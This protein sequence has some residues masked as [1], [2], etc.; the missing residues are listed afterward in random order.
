MA[1]NDR[2]QEVLEGRE[3]N[4]I[5]PFLWLHGKGEEVIREYIQK[6]MDTGIR[7]VC[8]ESRPH[9]EFAREG[10]WKDVTVALNEARERGMK[11]WILDDSHFPTGFAN[12]RVREAEDKLKR[13]FLV[14]REFDVEGPLND[15]HIRI[16]LENG[17]GEKGKPLT[18]HPSRLVACLMAERNTGKIWTGTAAD[19][20]ESYSDG[21]LTFHVPEGK[22][23]ISVILEQ[24][25][26]AV[27]SQEDY[28]N[29]LD[30]NS[31]QLLIDEVYESHYI[32]FKEFFGNTLAG[33]FSDEPGF[34][35]LTAQTGF[36]MDMKIGTEM[37]LPW[38]EKVEQLLKERLGEQMKSDLPLLWFE[39]GEEAQKIR[40]H[41]MDIVTDL[42]RENFSDYIGKWCEEHDVQYIGHIIEDNNTHTRLGPSCGHY[43]K[44]L[45]GQHMSGVDVIQ[46]QIMP[47]MNDAYYSF[48]LN[49][50]A[51]GAFYYYGLAKLGTSM[52][53]LETK[54][55][56]RAMCELYGAYGW[57]EGLKLMKWLTDHLLVRGINTYVPHAFSDKEFPDP[58]CPPHF[59]ANGK[60][61]QYPY[62]KYLFQYLNR[63]CHLLNG[64]KAS[65]HA[66]VLYHAEMEWMGDCL[67]FHQV[68][69]ELMENQTDYDVIPIEKLLS[70]KIKDR[71][72][73]GDGIS[74][75]CL[76]VPAAQAYPETLKEWLKEAEQYGFPVYQVTT[77]EFEKEDIATVTIPLDKVAETADYHGCNEIEVSEKIPYLRYYHYTHEKET[78][79]IHMFF[80]ESTLHE[81]DTKIQLHHNENTHIYIYDPY[82]N[83]L[84]IR[85]DWQDGNISLQL[86]PAETLYLIESN[87]S[88]GA[89]VTENIVLK[90][91]RTGFEF[92][93][94]A[95]FYQTPDKIEYV[96]TTTKLKDFF[97]WRPEFA[98]YIYYKTWIEKQER[99]SVLN[100]GNAYEAAE[101]FV[102]GKSAG[103]RINTPYR[104][105]L[106]GML[107]QE[108]NEIVVKIATN[109]VYA[110]CDRFSRNAVISPMGLMGPVTLE[111][112]GIRQAFNPYLPSYEYIPDGEPHVFCDRVYIYG[113]HDSFDGDLYC[114]NDYVCYSA[115][116]TDLS[117]WRYEC[118]IYRKNQDPRNADGSHCLWA[119][120]VT[121]GLDGKYYL[122]YCLDVLPEIGVAVC[123]T[124][125]GKYEFLG[126]VRYP[127]GS[128]LGRR[129]G[130]YIQ[131]DPGIF[132]DSDK[133]IYLYSGNAP[134]RMEDVKSTEKKS[135]QVMKLRS[136]MLTIEEGPVPVIP[137]ILNSRGTGYEGH[138]FFEASSVRKIGER[139]YFVY[140]DVNSSSLCYAVSEY[141]DSGY[142][143]GGVLIDICDNGMEGRNFKTNFPGNTHGG[144]EYI[145]GRWYIFYH[146]QTNHTQFS[147]QGCAEEIKIL[148]DGTIPQV[149]ITSCGLNGGPL[150]GKG[151]YEAR[152]A[153]NLWGKKGVTVLRKKDAESEYPYFTQDGP[154]REDHPNQYIA[155]IRDGAV[156][157][158]KYFTF[159]GVKN[160]TVF[161]RGNSDGK[162]I[163][164]TEPYGKICAEIV[165]RPDNSGL[166]VWNHYTGKVDIPDGV[167]GLFFKYEG[168]GKLDFLNFELS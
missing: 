88:Y 79:G 3:E 105:D 97:Q 82:E 31:V 128:I 12:G 156:C 56:G 44:A 118:V 54:T 125:A 4:Y 98:G 129:E 22:Y 153:C 160:I 142:Q 122:Y 36:S 23:R 92:E 18:K 21:W 121:K 30:K 71:V 94:T 19:I 103:V 59:Y 164:S 130:D 85:P 28:I 123:D 20:T 40:Y 11:V 9:P 139:Y 109:L 62:M 91:E 150:R 112:G 96:D 1:E 158:F 117:A 39:D 66:A 15:Y 41:Y 99:T 127:D 73:Y 64:G 114:M 17:L 2:L 55:R 50:E 47:E 78:T 7:A 101:V 141:P 58:D 135:S 124:P 48:V 84:T 143:F 146:R 102:N 60:D 65:I 35:N 38:D 49:K 168:E 163:I 57:M 32:H 159:S 95:A 61:P 151:I 144:I 24:T 37:P 76:F 93:I 87:K 81:V 5:L 152:I 67:M 83:R 145:N 131:F 6:I 113:S 52:A 167:H 46:H 69:K 110:Q 89:T 86:Q 53:H 111:S 27:I 75:R 80:N 8:L 72:L 132:I 116:V 108:Q 133:N 43:F 25:G 161:V 148:P 90:E 119:P 136:D 149:E 106:T 16:D 157:G 107:N 138:E 147:R 115:S 77:E 162:F 100:L 14:H 51:D 137:S 134:R 33:F 140:S 126:L 45:H 104:Y 29:M 13:K 10:W 34:Y 154:D 120:D 68:G 26:G 42:Y 166:K 70:M 165:L 74:Y 155:N 63:A